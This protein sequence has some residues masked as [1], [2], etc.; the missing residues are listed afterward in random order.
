MTAVSSHDDQTPLDSATIW[1]GLLTALAIAAAA[2]V[3]RQVSGQAMLS[4]M[5]VSVL[6]GAALRVM[7]GPNT[8]PRAGLAFASRPVLR[9]GIVLLGL[10]VTLAEIADL[11]V[12]AFAVAALTVLATYL[13][14]VLAGRLLGV[15]LP[16][17]QLV[18]AGTAV[19]GASAI[20]A[21]NSVARGSD[22]DVGYAVASVTLFGT[23]AML[24]L[25]LFAGPLGLDPI[26]YGIWS[27]ASIHEVAQVTAAA[28]QFGPEA[29]QTGTITKLIRVMLLAPLVLA[30]ALALRGRGQAGAVTGGLQFPWFVLGFVALAAVNGMID[31]GDQAQTV[32][33]LSATFLMSTGLAAMG[34]SLN[35][36][37]LQSQGLA[38]L[39]LSAFG[40]VFVV[41]FALSATL[42]FVH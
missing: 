10:Q 30:M 21:A 31:L 3:V 25:P 14:V 17:T 11:G 15:P 9:F 12:A 1:P 20:V 4:P 23:V 35:L 8:L 27:G 40:C 33:G 41:V 26:A 16:L 13:V 37:E 34:L 6:A 28:F 29:G 18:A 22:A 24:A 19:C 38:P 42:L 36:R 7:L 5:L 39:G 32:A 2:V